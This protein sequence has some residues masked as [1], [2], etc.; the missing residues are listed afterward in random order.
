M[1]L[2]RK[3]NVKIA[4]SNTDICKPIK[5]YEEYYCATYNGMIYSKISNKFLSPGITK[6]TGCKSVVL[7]FGDKGKSTNYVHRL[8][9]ESFLNPV[10][11]KTMVNHKDGI[12]VNNHISNLEWCSSS[13]NNNHAIASG[14]RKIKCTPDVIKEIVS[15]HIKA[16]KQF[17]AK[18]LSI[19][20]NI[21]KSVIH[22]ILKNHKYNKN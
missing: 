16:N 6:A 21:D 20:F 2:L 9:A 17:G 4:L 12:K 11:N 8:V 13:E 14:L 22:E 7:Y 10:V 18:A 19:K 1:A 15:Q 3:A 5:G